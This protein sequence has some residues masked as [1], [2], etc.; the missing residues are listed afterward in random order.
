MLFVYHN[1]PAFAARKLIYAYGEVFAIV[2]MLSFI[3][4]LRQTFTFSLI[5]L[6]AV[7]TLYDVTSVFSYYRLL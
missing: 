3:S 2:P 5:C 6:N 1:V 4:C 7:L